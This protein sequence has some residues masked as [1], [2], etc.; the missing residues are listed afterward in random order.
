MNCSRFGAQRP[1]VATS[2]PGLPE[3]RFRLGSSATTEFLHTAAS[4][5]RREQRSL[6]PIGI[7]PSKGVLPE[8]LDHLALNDPL[9]YLAVFLGVSLLML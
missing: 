9:I 6:Q 1:A 3:P 2:Q 5:V 4:E 7:P 8:L